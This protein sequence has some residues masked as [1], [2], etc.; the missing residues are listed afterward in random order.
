MALGIPAHAVPVNNEGESL[1]KNHWQ[2]IKS[3]S[4]QQTN[5]TAGGPMVVMQ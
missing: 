1:L 3:Q 5:N 2:W 4:P